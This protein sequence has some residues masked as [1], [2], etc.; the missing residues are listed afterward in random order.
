MY[1][2]KKWKE[3][4]D[5]LSNSP[6]IKDLTQELGIMRMMLEEILNDCND[7]Q[8]LLRHSARVTSTVDKIQKLVETLDKIESKSALQPAQLAHLANQWVQIIN[9]HVKDPMV[10]EQLSDDLLK[11]IEATQLLDE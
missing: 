4:V 8:D 9:I 5:A 1:Y 10:L 11:T 2:L 6:S 7:V 3:R